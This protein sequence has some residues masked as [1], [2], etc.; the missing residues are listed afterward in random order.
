MEPGPGLPDWHMDEPCRYG[1]ASNGLKYWVWKLKHR[2]ERERYARGKRYNVEQL[3][4]SE[5]ERAAD[6]LARHGDVCNRVARRVAISA[7]YH[8][9]D[10][11][12]GR[13][14]GGPWMSGHRE[15]AGG[16]DLP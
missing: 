4:T 5:Q 6:Y 14:C 11:S 9:D 15:D 12:A 16:L 10:R 7:A 2:V 13:R 1:E 8:D 3:R